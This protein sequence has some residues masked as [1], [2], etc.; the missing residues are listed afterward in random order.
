MVQGPTPASLL[1]LI[2]GFP[3]RPP[4]DVERLEV[5]AG[6]GHRRSL[7]EYATVV[8]ERVQAWLLE[9][10]HQIAS[11]APAIIAVHQDGSTRPYTYGKSEV[12][13]LGGDPELAYGL[14]LCRRGYVVVCPD[15]FGFE[16]RRL[17]VSPHAEQFAGSR[18]QLAEDGLDLTEDLYKGA[19]ANRLLFNGW[20]ALGRELFELSRAVDVLV[21]RVDVDHGRIGVIGHSAGGHLC[22]YLMYLDQRVKVGCASCGTWLFAHAFRPHVLRPLNGFGTFLCVPGMGAWGDTDDVLAGIAPRPY[23][24][25]RG[26][27]GED[28]GAG[29]LIGK[30]Q[31]R[32]AA[33][34]VSE[35]FRFIEHERGHVFPP[36]LR[37]SAYA[38]FDRWLVQ[39]GDDA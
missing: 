29:D 23:C 26:D 36:E 8:G 39:N 12:A 37:E 13:G 19:D 25:A 24:E 6:D 35:R 15:R 11:P 1:D 31:R 30:A 17:A 33:L 27:F 10:D 16:S 28:F 3:E 34:G 32:Y 4:L 14:E 22:P 20:T 7:I 2:G 38:W 5:A 18:I 21:Q 9:P